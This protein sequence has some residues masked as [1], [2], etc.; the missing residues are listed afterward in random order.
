MFGQN[1]VTKSDEDPTSF[2]LVGYS[3]DSSDPILMLSP[4][5]SHSAEILEA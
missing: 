5:T 1:I 2:T 3:A 4:A